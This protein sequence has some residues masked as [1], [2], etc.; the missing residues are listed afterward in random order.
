MANNKVGHFIYRLKDRVWPDF[1]CHFHLF[2]GCFAHAPILD[3]SW[4]ANK[5]LVDISTRCPLALKSS[6]NFLHSGST[7]DV[8]SKKVL[9][10]FGLVSID[11]MRFS[12]ANAA[13]ASSSMICSINTKQ[14]SDQP[15]WS[16]PNPD[17]AQDSLDH[18]MQILDNHNLGSSPPSLGSTNSAALM[19]H[20]L[21]QAEL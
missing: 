8:N 18:P 5:E 15:N 1:V 19:E 17:Q 21:H 3:S 13:E 11:Y 7:M 14:P 4:H 2:N 20:F 9:C 16:L 10:K 6:L 12:N